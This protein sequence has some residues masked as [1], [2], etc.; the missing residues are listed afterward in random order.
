MK[1][2]G[3]SLTSSSGHFVRWRVQKRNILSKLMLQIKGD[4]YTM[5]SFISLCLC[6]HY[7]VFSSPEPKAH[8]VSL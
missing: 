2:R 1:T 7:C 4:G 3:S 5:D 6:E 8:K